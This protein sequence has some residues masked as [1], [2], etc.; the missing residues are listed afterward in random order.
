MS[1]HFEEGESGDATVGEEGGVF[2]PRSGFV[3]GFGCLGGREGIEGVG[4]GIDGEDIIFS[5]PGS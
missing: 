1:G 3:E 4:G 5:L 2:S